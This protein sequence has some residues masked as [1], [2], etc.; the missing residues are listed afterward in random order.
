MQW[1]NAAPRPKC[2][3]HRVSARRGGAN[4]IVLPDSS[5]PGEGNRAP[6]AALRDHHREGALRIVEAQFV[7]CENFVVVGAV[8]LLAKFLQTARDVDRAG[9]VEGREVEPSDV[10]FV[11]GA[12]FDPSANGSRVGTCQGQRRMDAER[13]CRYPSTV[14]PGLR[15]PMA[16]ILVGCGAQSQMG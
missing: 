8:Q 3:R 1:W 9:A 13:W 10:E 4:C 16:R 11:C 14:S 12:I 6:H 2:G 15:A 7:G 5:L